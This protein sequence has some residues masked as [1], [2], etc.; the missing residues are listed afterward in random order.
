MPTG[1]DVEIRLKGEA[2]FTY[3]SWKD[4]VKEMDKAIAGEF[5]PGEMERRL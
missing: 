1:A 4:F 3:Q 2:K 5:P